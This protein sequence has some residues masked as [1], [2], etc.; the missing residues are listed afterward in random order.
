MSA[1]PSL[2]RFAE[3]W[4]MSLACTSP[5]YGQP[6]EHEPAMLAHL[7]LGTPSDLSSA[8]GT[9]PKLT[10][11]SMAYAALRCNSCADNGCRGT[12]LCSLPR[13]NEQASTS[14]TARRWRVEAPSEAQVHLQPGARHRTVQY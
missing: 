1:Y 9:G 2:L 11:H 4:R 13:P 8:A 6:P 10:G 12:N 14:I 3:T 7:D 5:C